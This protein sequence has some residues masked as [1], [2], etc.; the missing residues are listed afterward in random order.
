MQIRKNIKKI[1]AIGFIGLMSFGALAGCTQQITQDDFNAAV[2]SAK[3]AGIKE[4][5]A[6]APDVIGYTQAQMDQATADAVAVAAIATQDKQ[7]I[8]DVEEA[9]KEVE[10]KDSKGYLVDEIEIGAEFDVTLSDRQITLFDGEIDFDGDDYEAEEVYELI[11]LK[12]A[13]NG[14]NYEDNAFLI[15]PEGGIAYTLTLESTLNTS[16]IDEDETLDIDI[17]GQPVVISEW[18]GDEITFTKG[19]EHIFDENQTKT[20]NGKKIKAHII[21]A[22]DEN[23]YVTVHVDG[24]SKKIYEG[25]TRTVNDI[26]IKV[27]EVSLN[28]E[29]V[30]E[31]VLQI[32]EEVEVTIKDG[33]EY[34]ED[35]IYDVAITSNTFKL[36]LNEEFQDIEDEDDVDEDS[37]QALAEGETLCLPNDYVCVRYDGLV[38]EDVEEYDFKLYTKG[39]SDYVKV[40]GNLLK[41]INDYTKV[42]VNA[43]G[44]YDNDIELIDAGSIELGDTDLE[45]NLVGS[46]LTMDDIKLNLDLDILEVAGI[47]ISGKEDNYLT[48]YGI[49]IETPDDSV[50]DNEFTIIVPDE[51]LEAEITILSK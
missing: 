13:V 3:Q 38:V 45:L 4:G 5:K 35:S 14:D 33:D 36:V 43:S 26:E 41:G 18:D 11:D 10:L 34:E 15:I 19:E 6:T 7:V 40:T 27:I 24:K 2:N 23:A 21:S 42:Y 47:D 20:V 31:A 16:L 48:T 50:E 39:G 29:T 12:V 9:V 51:E 44:F 32:G 17:L 30:D 37:H 8:E 1:I 22:I 25:S 28:E 46:N 49:V